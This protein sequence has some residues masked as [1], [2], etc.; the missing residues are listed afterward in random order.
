MGGVMFAKL[1]VSSFVVLCLVM[2]SGVAESKTCST[3]VKTLDTVNG[4]LIN[5]EQ[6][7]H[8]AGYTVEHPEKEGAQCTPF[9]GCEFPNRCENGW[10]ISS[11]GG[12]GQCTPFSGCSFPN[13]CENGW[14]VAPGGGGG[15]CTPF[16]GCSFPARCE[17]G[18]CVK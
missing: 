10:C 5:L 11:S 14:C 9:G 4:T 7:L 6:L 8:P 13:R 12:G 16:D 17:N 1:L 3:G 2:I 18:W 15:E